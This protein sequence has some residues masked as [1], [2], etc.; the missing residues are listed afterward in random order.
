LQ[1]HLGNHQVMPKNI[2]VDHHPPAMFW[3]QVGENS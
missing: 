3:W 2:M 1:L